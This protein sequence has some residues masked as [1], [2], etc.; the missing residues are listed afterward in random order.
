MQRRPVQRL[1]VL[2]VPVPHQSPRTEHHN[3][4][5][6]RAARQFP[7]PLPVPQLR[8]PQS[9]QQAQS[10]TGQ[11]QDPLRHHEADVEEDVGGGK[12]GQGEKGD[13]QEE[14]GA[15]RRSLG[16]PQ[17]SKADRRRMGEADAGRAAVVVVGGAAGGGVHVG[18]AVV[19]DRAGAQPGLLFSRLL[20]PAPLREYPPDAALSD[21]EQG[22]IKQQAEGVPGV[23]EGGD[24]RY[25]VHAPVEAEGVGEE[26]QPEVEDREV[27]EGEEPG[28]EPRVFRG[29]VVGGGELGGVVL[30]AEDQHDG[31]GGAEGAQA[32]PLPLEEGK[33]DVSAGLISF[34]GKL[35]FM[36]DVYCFPA[37][38]VGAVCKTAGRLKILIVAK[39]GN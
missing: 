23:P 16:V 12:E 32:A 3:Q 29:G 7:E 13:A 38:E 15:R 2:P 19:A 30:Q 22:G 17:P 14:G 39:V 25:R 31:A 24:P 20:L 26:Q 11:I 8:T 10:G 18:E 34:Q 4:N 37:V 27:G 21:E 35:G 9:H 33:V 5:E 1:L 6:Q 28:E 36:G